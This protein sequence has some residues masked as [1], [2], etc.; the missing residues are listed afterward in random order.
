[1]ISHNLSS[2]YVLWLRSDKVKSYPYER[3]ELLV[4][5]FISPGKEQ[6]R[7]EKTHIRR[8]SRHGWCLCLYSR[9]V[10]A[11]QH[12]LSDGQLVRDGGSADVLGDSRRYVQ[13]IWG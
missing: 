2:T 12:G 5:V 8:V 10:F 6:R 11:G 13:L 7:L 4:G 1:M 3:N 9:P